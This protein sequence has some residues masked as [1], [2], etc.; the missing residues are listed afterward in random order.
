VAE[1]TPERIEAMFARLRAGNKQE[2]PRPG[3]NGAEAKKTSTPP[4]WMARIFGADTLQHETFAPLTWLLPDL[5]PEGLTLLV[6]RP[7]LGKSWLALDIALGTAATRFVL[8]T[9]QPAAGEVLYLALEDGKRRLQRR[10][11]KLLPTFNGTWPSGLTFATEWPR[12]DQGGLVD[13]E[14]WIRHT[15]EKGKSPRLIV[16][17]TLARFRRP[18]AGKNA[19]L[20]DYAALAELQKLPTKYNLAIVAVHHDRKAAADDV[21]DTVSGTLGTIA[22]VDVIAILKRQA[23][24]VALHITGRD[25]DGAEKAVAFNKETCRWTILGE[26]AEVRRSD[27]RARVLTVLQDAGESLPISEIIS[28]AHLVNRN[29]ADNLLARMAK[30]GD[31]ERLKRGLY[32]LPANLTQSEIRGNLTH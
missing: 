9:L 13:L 21:F 30:D 26:A 16:I 14:S 8:G 23:G 20:E 25:I 24:A 6:S 19:Y 32:G 31:V 2:E 27:E 5:V 12:A 18:A 28:L 10:L 11:S 4:R 15:I 29:A 22:P 1:I 3:A 7:K 17:D